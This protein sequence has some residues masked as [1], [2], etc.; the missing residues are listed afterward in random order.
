MRFETKRKDGI[1]SKEEVEAR[2]AECKAKN[3]CYISLHPLTE[4]TAFTVI[5]PD[6]TFT[7][8]KKY[9]EQAMKV[10]E[11]LGKKRLTDV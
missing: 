7:M 11:A 10:Y 1:M 5:G 3:I 8:L 4:A 9:G 2:N 6:G